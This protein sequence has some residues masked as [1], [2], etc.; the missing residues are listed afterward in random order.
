MVASARSFP[1]VLLGVSVVAFT[2]TVRGAEKAEANFGDDVR[3]APFVVNGKPLSISIHAR[4]ADDRKYAGQF[5]EEVVGI[6]YE[7]IGK[8]TGAG[9]VVIGRKGEPHPVVVMQKFLAMAAAGQL[10]PAVAARAGELTAWMQDWKTTLH[11]EEDPNEKG[12]KVTFDIIP[13][14]FPA[15]AEAP[16]YS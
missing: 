7:T 16:R 1:M 11:L 9:L 10:D 8:S 13:K 2:G 15:R 5:A 12:F 3:L 14:R 4:T 6:A